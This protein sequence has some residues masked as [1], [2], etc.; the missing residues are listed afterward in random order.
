MQGPSAV[1]CDMQGLKAFLDTKVRQHKLAF[2]GG[3]YML[4]KWRVRDLSNVI[5]VVI[6]FPI[7]PT[8]ERM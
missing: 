3:H 1:E 4:Q 2:S 7:H 5:Y 8:W 6:C